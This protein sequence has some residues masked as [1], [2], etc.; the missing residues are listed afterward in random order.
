M[1][2]GVYGG[3]HYSRGDLKDIPTMCHTKKWQ[4][5]LST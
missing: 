4:E 2:E 3:Q 1:P 5:D